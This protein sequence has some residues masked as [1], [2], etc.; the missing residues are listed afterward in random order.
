VRQRRILKWGAIFGTVI[1][2][3]CF[4]FLAINMVSRSFLQARHPSTYSKV[5]SPS[6]T[7]GPQSVASPAEEAPVL[8]TPTPTPDLTPSPTEPLAT[9]TPS[10]PSEQPPANRSVAPT[11]TASP[12]ATASESPTNRGG[13][14]W[15][16]R[17][18]H[19]HSGSGVPQT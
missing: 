12:E 10:P 16:R 2:G 5:A 11:S 4:I 18:H 1:A 15:H 8:A 19:R 14:H 17:L 6:A 3:C 9:P 7:V 13:R